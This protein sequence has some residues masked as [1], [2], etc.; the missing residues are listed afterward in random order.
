MKKL[1][2]L[3]LAL[4]L[5]ALAV[6]AMAGDVAVSG[7]YTFDAED[8]SGQGDVKDQWYDDELKV[9]VKVTSGAVTLGLDLEVSDDEYFDLDEHGRSTVAGTS[10]VSYTDADD[11]PYSDLVD[12]Y[13]VA[14]ATP[15]EGLGVKIGEYGLSFGR[16][17]AL[18]DDPPAHEIGVTYNKLANVDLGLY[19][20]KVY[21]AKNDDDT[22]IDTMA[23]T[24]GV[25]GVQIFQKLNFIYLNA[26]GEDDP[27]TATTVEDVDAGYI[28]VDT[29]FA[30]GPVDLAIEYGN[31]TDGEDETNEASFTYAEISFDRLAGFDINLELFDSSE[32]GDLEGLFGANN[33]YPYL[34]YGFRAGV[35]GSLSAVRLIGVSGSYK[36][37]EKMTVSGKVLAQGTEKVSDESVGMEIDAH[38]AYKF[39]DNASVQLSYGTWSPGDAYFGGDGDTESDMRARFVFTF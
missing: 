29:A 22:D 3:L 34:L 6:P 23:L 38:L 4:A 33:F 7:K 30:A 25:K 1:T 15:V 11:S 31:I 21:E 32:D 9:N 27:A 24:A 16:G 2:I 39:A 13:Y 37:N 18:Y 12:N 10:T 5:T 26:T 28:G 17:V 19:I 14:W 8:F 20:G 35:N 36:I